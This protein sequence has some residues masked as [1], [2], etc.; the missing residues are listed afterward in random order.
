MRELD[1]V[2]VLIDIPDKQIQA[3]MRGVIVEV[4]EVD[5]AFLVEVF[6][7]EQ[8]IDVIYLTSEQ[9]DVIASSIQMGDLVALL[10]VLPPYDAGLVGRVVKELTDRRIAITFDLH[11]DNPPH[12]IEI[13]ID[14]VRLLAPTDKV[15]V[16]DIIA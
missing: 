3:G 12:H 1:S 13:G 7:D 6:D 10:E 4:L 16:R 8:T 14:Q 5:T 15:Y 11:S 2:T 9:I